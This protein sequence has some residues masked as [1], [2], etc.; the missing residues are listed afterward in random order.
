[1]EG[2][3]AMKRL[4]SGM[5]LSLLSISIF[6]AT[7]N[8]QLVKAS[9]TIYIR[10][11]GSVDPPTAPIRRDGNIYTITSDITEPVV[12]QK[13]NIVIDGV[14]YTVQGARSGIGIDLSNTMNVTVK[15]TRIVWFETGILLSDSS[16][17]TLSGN[18]LA[19]N[20]KYGVSL[21]GSSR[22]TLRRN[23]IISNKL[24]I[25]LKGSF[26]TLSGNTIENNDQGI[27]LDSSSGNELSDNS[28]T[29]NQQ[30]ILLVWSSGNTLSSNLITNNYYD[31]IWLWASSRNTLFN[32]S[33]RS[34]YGHGIVLYGSSLNTLDRNNIVDNYQ[35]GLYLTSTIYSGSTENR[36][37]RNTVTRN[38]GGIQI[39]RE[40]WGIPASYNNLIYHNNF[41][42]NT[43]Q[44]RA[45]YE[46]TWDDGYPSGGNH[47]SDYTGMDELSGPYQNE[48]G[49]DG[50]GDTPHIIDA[51]NRD[52][53]PLMNPWTPPPTPDFSIT[54]SP[55]SLIIQQGDLATSTITI[56][57]VNGFDQPV[58]LTVS[59][60]PTGVT[61]TL[62]PEQVTPPPDG[63][64]T[65]TLTVS[66]GTTATPGSYTL[67]VTGTSGTITH[68]VDIIL[69][70]AGAP[71]EKHLQIF[72]RP[73][74]PI[75]ELTVSYEWIDRSDGEN[76]YKISKIQIKLVGFTGYYRLFI[77]DRHKNILWSDWGWSGINLI[78]SYSSEAVPLTPHDS[79]EIGISLKGVDDIT[80]LV[81]PFLK[82]T[83]WYIKVFEK[84]IAGPYSILIP[85]SVLMEMF[86]PEEWKMWEESP[87][88]VVK[89]S[90][91]QFYPESPEV[92]EY[93]NMVPNLHLAYLASPA[94]LRVYD[95]EGRVTGLVNGEVREEIPNSAY[96]N[97][98]V[99]ILSPSDSYRHEV[100]GTEVGLY[101][102]TIA[103]II[104]E[105]GNAFIAADIPISAN[106]I[107]QYTV[108]WGALAL[109]EEGVTVQVDSDGDGVFELT[110]TSDSELTRDEFLL[111]S[112][113]TKPVANAGS[114]QTVY[115]GA[116]ITFDAG[117]SSDN[118]GIVSYEWDF[119]D[120]TTG[121]GKTANHTYAN[122]GTYIVTLTVKD[123]A[124]NSDTDSI[125]VTVLAV[126]AFPLWIVGALT[127]LLAITA[128]AT[129]L[130][131]RRKQSPTKG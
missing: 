41:I 82:F 110:F 121:T 126:E 58:Q 52:R 16:G 39:Y 113:I 14:G 29:N 98:T 34:N 112:D 32:N 45:Q 117:G 108:D 124:G 70:I 6:T 66:V 86:K 51:K 68:S 92:P 101:R 7:F 9:G 13:N 87:I 30:H 46:N 60:A 43:V 48:T 8:I 35:Y 102:L 33:V 79:Y 11:D 127:A 49:S 22:N 80:A 74:Q 95:S 93:V 116:T 69:E 71:L 73:Y 63:S 78:K 99:M 94:E 20:T 64:T 54:A 57:S 21:V 131:K 31:G 53:Y 42:N 17:N 105:D 24:G 96:F 106:T 37:F 18:T 15:S 90:T 3:E 59:G 36:I 62:S 1:V 125:T 83:D 72:T 81:K 129:L 130:W 118:I 107:H 12:V 19:N 75:A 104:E 77:R 23:N 40:N 26:N 100:A 44:V 67:T 88:V 111:L 50:I 89:S 122:S 84:M 55:T 5:I 2:E 91:T 10:A 25:Y 119:G 97:K 61:T 56:A 28:I 103:L 65:S 114:N 123:A 4:L 27:E 85:H 128:V 115:V 47:W 76:I 109:G 38:G 120:G